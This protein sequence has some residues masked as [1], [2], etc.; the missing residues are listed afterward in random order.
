MCKSENVKRVLVPVQFNKE[1]E[2]LL[3]YAGQLAGT[4]GAEL[5]LLLA[6]HTKELT[7]TQQSRNIQLLRTF[8]ERLLMQ[9]KTANVAFECVVRPGN[10]SDCII[11]VIQDYSV[12]MV[13]M[14]TCPLHQEE[15]HVDPDHA[16][17]IMEKVA[18]PVMVVPC[19]ARFQ[20]LDNLVFAT[21]FTDQEE[22]VLFQIVS[23]AEQVGAKLTLVQVYGQA[24]RQQLSN[25]KAAMLQTEKLLQGHNVAFKLL[26]EED[27]LEGISDFAEAA[28]ADMLI[29]AT[30][31]NFLMKRLFSSNY[32]KTM[33]YHTQYPLLTFR[34]LKKKPCSGCCENCGKNKSIEQES[35]PQI[36]EISL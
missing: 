33:A 14:E 18:C 29:L 24:E 1:S 10:L 12:D 2:E 22:H 32:I 6:S 31:D 9:H 20:N 11:S 34:Q 30:Q 26:E 17:A 8:G 21:D 13:L 35:N 3:R 28:T 19:T 23:F 25:Y 15:E 27:V 4:L 5:V 16:A 7:F 36:I